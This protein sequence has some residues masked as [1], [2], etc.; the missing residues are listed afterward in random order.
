MAQAIHL[1]FVCPTCA[2]EDREQV[3][4]GPCEDCGAP[5]QLAQDGLAVIRY[6]QDSGHGWL[7]VTP[8]Q[9]ASYCIT[10]AMISPYSYRSRDHSMI[11]LEENCDAGVFIE[12]FRRAHGEDPHFTREHQDPTPIRNWPGFGQRRS[13][14]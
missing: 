13:S 6:V 14:W 2:R 3:N 9:L 8:A 10:E 11:A 7:I 1:A 12:A 4:P 5:M